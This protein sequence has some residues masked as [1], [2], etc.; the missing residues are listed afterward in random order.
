MRPRPFCFYP[1]F[2]R[3]QLCLASVPPLPCSASEVVPEL[4]TLTWLGPNFPFTPLQG[5]V[6]G[7]RVTHIFPHSHKQWEPPRRF[8]SL[9]PIAAT[10]FADS[11]PH[12]FSGLCLAAHGPLPAPTNLAEFDHLPTWKHL[13]HKFKDK[14]VRALCM[15]GMEKT[16]S[17]G[18]H[19]EEWRALRGQAGGEVLVALSYVTQVDTLTL[20][21]NVAWVTPAHWI[22]YEYKT[23]ICSSLLDVWPIRNAQLS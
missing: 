4:L 15:G 6:G 23:C 2:V 16:M 19:R 5:K 10:T 17:V 18:K 3:G 22:C 14:N 20:T 9:H 7:P 11:D 21:S 12:P 13:E 1:E 8:R